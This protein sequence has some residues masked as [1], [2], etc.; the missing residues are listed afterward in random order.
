MIYTTVDNQWQ[1]RDEF[2]KLDRDYFTSE[3]YKAIFD[4]FNEGEE[5][6]SLDVIAIC[7]ELTWSSWAELFERF[8]TQDKE[9]VVSL[10]SDY[11]Y[12]LN[13]SEDRVLYFNY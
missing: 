7:C 9:E 1:L 4:Y 3:E 11:T 8:N 2:I 12:V 13:F 10:L 5:G 6:Y